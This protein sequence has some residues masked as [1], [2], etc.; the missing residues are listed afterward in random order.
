MFAAGVQTVSLAQEP[1]EAG[2]KAGKGPDEVSHFE[3]EPSLH[4]LV[5]QHIEAGWKKRSERPA[6]I[7]SD[8]EFLRRV[9]LDLTG[10]IPTADE[11]RAFLDDNSSDKREKLIDRLLDS[12]EY[13]LHMARV[14]DVMLT[15][16]RVATIHFADEHTIES[17]QRTHAA[18]L[19]QGE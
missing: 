13:A 14:L 18:G 12:P 7:A 3:S 8:T 17:V 19:D 5:D 1:Q 4:E 9:C 15:E 11:V 6:K 2:R 10:I 16:R